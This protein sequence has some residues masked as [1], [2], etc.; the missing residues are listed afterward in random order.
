MSLII[1]EGIIDDKGVVTASIT[2]SHYMPELTEHTLITTANI[3]DFKVFI[4]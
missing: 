2:S 1:N 3:I 4:A